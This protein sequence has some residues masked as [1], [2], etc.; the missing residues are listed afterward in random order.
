M[1]DADK[2]LKTID[3]WV[4]LVENHASKLSAKKNCKY[5]IHYKKICDGKENTP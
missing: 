1:K 2:S 4:S 3:I 5:C